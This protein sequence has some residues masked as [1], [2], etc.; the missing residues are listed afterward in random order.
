MPSSSP[1]GP[2]AHRQ[3][4]A[5]SEFTSGW[6]PEQGFPKSLILCCFH[7]SAVAAPAV[8]NTSFCSV[9]SSLTKATTSLLSTSVPRLQSAADVSTHSKHSIYPS[10]NTWNFQCEQ[11]THTA[12]VRDPR[13]RQEPS[14]EDRE[15]N[16]SKSGQDDSNDTRPQVLLQTSPISL[17]GK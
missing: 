9:C 6:K 13:T 4:P 1:S 5:T 17:V 14:V 10:T 11:L 16:T 15:S 12:T 8:T 3:P 2:A 7:H